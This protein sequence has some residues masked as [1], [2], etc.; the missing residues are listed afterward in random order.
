MRALFSIAALII[1]VAVIG[2]VAKKQLSAA[3][4]PSVA[5]SAEGQSPAGEGTQARRP[6]A[7]QLQQFQKNLDQAVQQAPRRLGDQ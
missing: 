1:V 6:A 5:V 7:E 4:V 3:T 2:V